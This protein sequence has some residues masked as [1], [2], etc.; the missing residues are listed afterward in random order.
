MNK[1]IDLHTHSTCSDGTFTPAQVV[2]AAK[3]AGLSAIAL[4]DHDT[5][6]GLKEAIDAG[7]TYGI[8]VITG[9]EF[10]VASD[11]EMHLL[12]LGFD[13]DCPAITS[14]LDEMIYQREIRNHKVVELLKNIGIN[15]SV[16]DILAE[17]T[18]KVTGRSQIAKAMIKKGYVTTVKEAFDKYLS[19]GK[20]AFVKQT[21]LSPEK[22]I[23]IIK[24]SGGVSSLAHLNQIGKSDEDLYKILTHLK[25][26]GLDAVEGYYTEYTDD[27]SDRYRKMAS[28]I[29][30]KL[31]GGSDFHGENKD[32]YNIGTGKGNLKITYDLLKNLV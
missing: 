20:P 12:G 29:G 25:S 31:T 1:Y 11:T 5:I 14:V 28:D 22:A 15:I 2:K 7:K 4:T 21:S 18:S 17:A 9:I 3:D 6:D 23:E 30:L 13:I 24:Q 19:H 10:S 8:E 27:M 26:V 32:G 16:D